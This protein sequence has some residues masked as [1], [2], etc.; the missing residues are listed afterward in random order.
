MDAHHLRNEMFEVTNTDVQDSATVIGEDTPGIFIVTNNDND[1]QGS[2][3]TT[4]H[5][6]R[7]FKY[8]A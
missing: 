2:A 6:S 1:S 7:C 8:C 4:R 3:Q 5:V